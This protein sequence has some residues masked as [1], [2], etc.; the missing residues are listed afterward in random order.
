MKKKYPCMLHTVADHTSDS[1]RRTPPSDS[2]PLPHFVFPGGEIFIQ[3]GGE[4]VSSVAHLFIDNRLQL[5]S[6][7]D[8]NKTKE[9]RNGKNECPTEK[10]GCGWK[11][12]PYAL[13]SSLT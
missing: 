1:S 2:P 3:C 13:K 11:K 9:H 5:L 8:N 6:L 10:L 4:I 7:Q 12:R